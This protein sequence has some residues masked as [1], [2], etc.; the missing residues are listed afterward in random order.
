MYMYKYL[1]VETWV[2]LVKE[3][4]HGRQKAGKGRGRMCVRNSPTDSWLRALT[5]RRQK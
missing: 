1:H 2:N 5:R 4:R 3:N